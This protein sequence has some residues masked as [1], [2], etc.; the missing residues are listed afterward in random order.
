[1]PKITPEHITAQ[2]RTWLDTAYHHQGRLKKSARG[3]GGVDCLGLVI[4]VIDEL[5][6]QDGNG[7][8]LVNAD[9]LAV[10]NGANAA[11]LGDEIIQFT[12]A[13][14]LTDGQ[15]QLS[16]L[17]RGRMGTEWAMADHLAGERFVLLDSRLNRLEM[18]TSLIGLSRDYKAVSVGQTLGQTEAES[19]AY[20]GIAL[21]PY[22]PVHISGARDAS[23]NL[24]LAWVRRTRLD[25]QW[26]DGVDIPR[27]EEA[28]AYEVD[29]L[30]GAE[31]VRTLSVTTPSASYSVA[32]Q[33]TDF[34][35]PQSSL[36]VQVYQLSAVVGRGFG[37]EGMV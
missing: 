26:G 22:A 2:A 10:L 11:L 37:G 28:E 15:Y 14:L 35:S 9:E 6:M 7:N 5:G 25:G 30:D 21:R 23:G 18:P 33:T 31:V 29:I 36:S 1:M 16:G 12:T 3:K 20:Q 32:E 34:G 27:N 4:G 19:F 8:P 13:N 24:T 17:L